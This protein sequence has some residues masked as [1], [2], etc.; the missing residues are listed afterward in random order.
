MDS[1]GIAAEEGLPPQGDLGQR[2]LRHQRSRAKHF[3]GV[4]ICCGSHS[5]RAYPITA[6]LLVRPYPNNGQR[7]PTFRTK[8][9]FRF[10]TNAKNLRLI[11]LI[12]DL[13][14]GLF[15]LIEAAR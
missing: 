6:L 2:P 15:G 1:D 3:C 7:E 4:S 10:G 11:N 9:P 14:G 8:P 12:W 5:V 13:G